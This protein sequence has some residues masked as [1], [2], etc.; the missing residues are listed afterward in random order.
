MENH[1][2]TAWLVKILKSVQ[3]MHNIYKLRANRLKLF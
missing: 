2:K 1:D 3:Q